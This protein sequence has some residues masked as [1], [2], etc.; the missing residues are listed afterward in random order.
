MSQFVPAQRVVQRVLDL[1]LSWPEVVDDLSH[2]ESITPIQGYDTRLRYCGEK[3]QAYVEP[4]TYD[5]DDALWIVGLCLRRRSEQPA[6]L[7]V[8]GRES[9]ARKSSKR[10]GSGSRWPTT[11]KEL[12]NRINAHPRARVENG[13][14]HLRVF[15]DGR[16]VQAL[17]CS[18][19]DHR[20]LLNACQILR[21]LGVDV[22]R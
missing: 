14:K 1:G 13:G 3:V 8:V 17:P 4:G 20:A 5:G 15:L 2:A 22:R 9:A 6:D 7:Q 21:G 19:S 18:A 11:W 12:V 16:Q 10:G